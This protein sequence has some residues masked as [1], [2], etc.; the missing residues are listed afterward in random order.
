MND[1]GIEG[2]RSNAG[3]SDHLLK[4]RPP[5]IGGG[6]ARLDIFNGHA[7]LFGLAPFVHLPELVRD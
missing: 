6:C 2:G 1:D 7:V 3:L 5:V 4:D